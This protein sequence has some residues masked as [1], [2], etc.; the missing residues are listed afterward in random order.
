MTKDDKNFLANL[1][2]DNA[3]SLKQKVTAG[4]KK[5]GGKLWTKKGMLKNA[6]QETLDQTAYHYALRFQI[7]KAAEL[8]KKNTDA[9]SLVA[10]EILLDILGEPND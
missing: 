1:V 2:T 10:R 7:G 4:I 6:E 5:H 9:N 8:L 3:V